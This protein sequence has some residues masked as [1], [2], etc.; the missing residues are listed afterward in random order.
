[1]LTGIIWYLE[2]HS[3]SEF[4]SPLLLFVLSISRTRIIRKYSLPILVVFLI[5]IA[6]FCKE[7]V[8]FLKI[9]ENFSVVLIYIFHWILILFFL[10]K[11]YIEHRFG[12]FWGH[13]A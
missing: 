10:I 1:M 4:I 7:I 11:S 8:P 13:D 12:K 2:D 5:S 3:I 9:K 6:I